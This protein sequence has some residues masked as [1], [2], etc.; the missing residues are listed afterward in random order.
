MKTTY[1]N[2]SN[3][4]GSIVIGL[5]NVSRI[6][7]LALL[8]TGLLW[9]GVAQ[10]QINLSPLSIDVQAKKGQASGVIDISNTSNS[11][12]RARIYAEPFTYDRENGFKVLTT[13][14]NDLR[15]YLRFSPQE[16]NLPPGELRRVRM[17]VKLP[18]NLPD[19]EY[20]VMIFTEPLT[21]LS[22]D[23]KANTATIVTRIGSALYVRQG[24]VKANITVDSAGWNQDRNLVQLLVRNSGKASTQSFANWSL[25]QGGKVLQTGETPKMTTIAE[26]ERYLVLQNNKPQKTA[27]PAGIYQLTG[28]LTSGSENQQSQAFS[29][30]INITPAGK[31]TTLSMP[32]SEH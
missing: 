1:P 8:M 12:F 31:K 30:S 4:L 21:D 29:F 26:G 18:A 28:K 5:G 27:L 14:P 20:R 24:N 6:S 32:I 10:A 11:V 7:S 3:N 19:G 16:L 13:S 9:G 15:P 17:T 2:L 25:S 23:K 22:T